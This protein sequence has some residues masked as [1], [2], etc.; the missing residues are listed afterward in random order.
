MDVDALLVAIDAE[1]DAEAEQILATADAEVESS[2]RRGTTDAARLEAEARSSRDGQLRAEL[3]RRRAVAD[4]E[5]ARVERAAIEDGRQ[6][7]DRELHR[8]L[9]G[10]RERPDYRRLLS[11]LLEEAASVAI[12]TVIRVDPADA[13]L[14]TDVAG[15]MRLDAEVR[16]DLE[17]IGGLAV[18][19]ADGRLVIDTL[20][21]RLRN[22]DPLL[23]V[24][25]AS[26]FMR[27]VD[28]AG[29]PREGDPGGGSPALSA[30]AGTRDPALEP[31]T[32][33]GGG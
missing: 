21:E 1:A 33:D 27:I 19:T 20:E 25:I 3:A 26:E 22:A 12:P 32:T 7:I 5:L 2:R 23:R 18:Q 17:S 13:E 24:A 28:A 15:A 11:V 10:R 14:V 4:L 6:A 9:A 29:E 30:G 16:P 8:L 31:R